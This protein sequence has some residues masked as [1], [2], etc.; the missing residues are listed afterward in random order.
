MGGGIRCKLKGGM[1]VL[2]MRGGTPYFGRVGSV[3]GYTQQSQVILRFRDEPE[4]TLVAFP[5]AEILIARCGP[6][7]AVQQSSILEIHHGGD[8]M[9]MLN[10]KRLFNRCIFNLSLEVTTFDIPVVG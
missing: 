1:D 5:D 2:V 7:R 3:L 8:T 10:Q 9:F 6:E 4:R